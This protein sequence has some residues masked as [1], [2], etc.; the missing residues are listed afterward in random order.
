LGKSIYD[1]LKNF[2]CV[3][4][5]RDNL[6][7]SLSQAYRLNQALGIPAGGEVTA[8]QRCNDLAK[9]EETPDVHQ[10]RLR[11]VCL[12]RRVRNVL[13]TTSL[14]LGICC[15]LVDSVR[16]CRAPTRKSVLKFSASRSGRFP[17]DQRWGA[18]QVM[19]PRL[20]PHETSSCFP[21]SSEFIFHLSSSIMCY[22]DSHLSVLCPSHLLGQGA[23]LIRR[24]RLTHQPIRPSCSSKIL[25]R[26]LASLT[27]TQH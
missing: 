5:G 21:R 12:C 24:V 22:Q 15:L 3:V 1:R 11:S 25:R 2:S 17:L 23:A 14:N 13:W 9:S 10:R 20:L 6:N 19:I 18:S 26:D 8:E 16:S 27:M 7:K 4:S